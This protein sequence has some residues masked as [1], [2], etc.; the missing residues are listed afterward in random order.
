[1]QKLEDAVIPM[2]NNLNIITDTQMNSFKGLS[3]IPPLEVFSIE[4]I[5]YLNQL[6]KSLFKDKRSRE[7]PDVSTF[8]FF[9]RKA[10]IT[11]L[12]KQ[13][14]KNDHIRLGKGVVFHIAPS[15]VPV[16]FAYSLIAGLLSGNVNIVR[17]PSKDFEQIQIIVEAINKISQEKKYI[18]FSKRII[19]V[20]YDNKYEEITKEISSICNARVIWGGDSTIDSIRKHKLHPRASDLTFSDRYS[21]CIINADKLA[22]EKKLDPIIEG[23]YNDTYLFDQNACTSPH[24]IVWQGSKKNVDKSQTLFWG[25]L[26]ELVKEKYNLQPIHAVDKLT[27]FYD[28]SIGMK[29]LKILDKND[30]LLWRIRLNSLDVNIENFRSNCGYFCEYHATSFMEIASIANTKYQTLS[31]YGFTQNELTNFISTETPF[32]IDRIVPIGKT[33]DFSLFWDGH[34]LINSLSRTVEV[35]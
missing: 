6:S 28:Q 35:I 23:F 1:M 11:A 30:N 9:C 16:N 19:L 2:K 4:V 25:K 26:H 27:D 21:L 18:L 33:M 10:N 8:A 7:Y 29:D 3:N 17:V 5:D 20:R 13:H 12:K 32:G 31:Y 24:L 22:K 15:N 34:D 14:S